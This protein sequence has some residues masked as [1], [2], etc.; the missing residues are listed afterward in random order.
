MA[1]R[2]IAHLEEIPLHDPIPHNPEDEMKIV[3]GTNS[4]MQHGGDMEDKSP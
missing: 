4:V 2:Q 1:D 3:S